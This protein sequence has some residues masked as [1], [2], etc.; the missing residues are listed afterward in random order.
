SG[1]FLV[2][3]DVFRNEDPGGA[4]AREI[5]DLRRPRERVFRARQRHLDPERRSAAFFALDADLAA[6]QLYQALRDREPEPCAAELATDGA[7]DLGE[8]L[9]EVFALLVGDAD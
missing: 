9:E 3:L 5:V 8:A 4:G 6:H 2:D 1:Q 7:V